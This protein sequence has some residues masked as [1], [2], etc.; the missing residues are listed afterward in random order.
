MARRK[1]IIRRISDRIKRIVNP[2]EPPK[3]PPPSPPPK[4]PPETPGETHDRRMREIF[5]RVTQSQVDAEYQVWRELFQEH[6][7]IFSSN[8]EIEQYWNMFLRAFFLTTKDPGH[9]KR[10]TFY[11]RT[12][13][14]RKRIDWSLWRDIMGYG[15][16]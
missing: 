10:S 2:P 4:P 5:E 14:P 13:I 15:K 8:Q 16:H 11:N 7:V 3:P 12:G 6:E 1:G 9:V